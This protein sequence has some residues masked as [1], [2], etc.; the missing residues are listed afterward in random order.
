MMA[1]DG[2]LVKLKLGVVGKI[3]GVCEILGWLIVQTYNI[4]LRSLCGVGAEGFDVHSRSKSVKRRIPQLRV[5]VP[6]SMRKA[7]C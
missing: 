1:A 2:R 4:S 5:S 7:V 3:L 6:L